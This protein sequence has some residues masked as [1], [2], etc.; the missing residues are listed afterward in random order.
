MSI[1][2]KY[3]GEIHE[4]EHKLKQIENK[5]FKENT[6]ANYDGNLATNVEQLRTM[7]NELLYKI[8][9][10]LDSKSEDLYRKYDECMNKPKE[11]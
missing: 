1:L 8:D 4:I 3:K 9:N 10:N 11:S 5:R 6:G 7:I 2:K